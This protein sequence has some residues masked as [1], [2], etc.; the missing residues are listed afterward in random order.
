MAKFRQN[1]TKN[2]KATSM[3]KVILFI[4]ILAAVLFYLMQSLNN[5]D[6]GEGNLDGDYTISSEELSDSLYFIPTGSTGE[7]VH[8][9]HY[10]LSY[11]EKYEQAEWVAYELT[12]KSIQVPNVPRAKRFEDDPLVST[13]SETFYDYKGSGYSKGHLAPA[14]DMAFSK[15]AMEESFFM[16]NMSPQVIPFNG[17]VWNELENL[18]R[19]WAYKNKRLIVVTGPVFSNGM[20]KIKGGVAV[21]GEYYK[22]LLDFDNPDQKAIG[23]ILPNKKSSQPMQDFAVS[24]DEVERRT[25]LNFFDNLMDEEKQAELESEFDLSKWPLDKKLYDKRVNVWNNR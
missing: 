10:S 23:F 8:H 6:F 20:K 16:S 14:G 17:G 3:V 13:R 15:E 11:V 2:G 19:D 5:I 12:K 9:T 21:P 18:V 7:I 22:V 25:G 4:A 24:V 1:H